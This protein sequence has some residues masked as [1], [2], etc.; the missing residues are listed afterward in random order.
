MGM[1]PRPL[2]ES[3]AV[4]NEDWV[5]FMGD[6]V[7]F[8]GGTEFSESLSPMQAANLIQQYLGIEGRESK[9]FTI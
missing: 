5:H 1:F 4:N 8:R 2:V 6:C 9:Y 3:S 7:A